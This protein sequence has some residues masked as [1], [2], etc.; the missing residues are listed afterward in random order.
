MTEPKL[1]YQLTMRCDYERCEFALACHEI[2]GVDPE[3]VY[4]EDRKFPREN[5][6]TIIPEYGLH[7]VLLTACFMPKEA[8]FLMA[9]KMG[10]FIYHNY[11]RGPLFE[12]VKEEWLLLRRPVY[13]Q[14]W[15]SGNK[16]VKAWEKEF[17]DRRTEGA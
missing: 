5:L 14:K 3:Y 1:L 11:N 6:G 10:I 17:A 2:E 4:L 13:D 9:R 12:R 15:F 16:K 8:V 7:K